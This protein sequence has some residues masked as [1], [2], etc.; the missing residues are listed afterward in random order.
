MNKHLRYLTIGLLGLLPLLD[1][2]GGKNGLENKIK[3]E[4]ISE[5][6]NPI[7]SQSGFQEHAIRE[8]GVYEFFNYRV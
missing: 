7:E 8:K 5:V 3:D 4:I 1:C 2:E 6:E